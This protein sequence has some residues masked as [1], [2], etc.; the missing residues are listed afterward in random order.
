MNTLYRHWWVPQ[1]SYTEGV[2]LILDSHNAHWLKDEIVFSLLNSEKLRKEFATAWRLKTYD[3]GSAKLLVFLP[4]A[5]EPM[6]SIG[7]ADPKGFPTEIIL[8]LINQV[9]V[10]PSEQDVINNR[11]NDRVYVS[12]REVKQLVS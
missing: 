8:L 5:A 2:K 4:N 11:A 3:D 9:L 7:V 1:I 10:L 12:E 6:C